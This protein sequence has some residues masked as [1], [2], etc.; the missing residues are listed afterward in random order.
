[1]AN[2]ITETE[3]LNPSVITRSYVTR[4]SGDDGRC[5]QYYY[6]GACKK[7]HKVTDILMK[8][9]EVYET[10][11]PLCGAKHDL[12]IES[13]LEVYAK[14]KTVFADTGN[15]NY[16]VY[17]R[18]VKFA[19][20]KKQFYPAN[21]TYTVILK[22]E[23]GKAFV[24]FNNNSA[25]SSYDIENI[26]NK[27]AKYFPHELPFRDYA[28]FRKYNNPRLVDLQKFIPDRRDF[29]HN[30]YSVLSINERRRIFYAIDKHGSKGAFKAIA[31][32]INS[33][34]IRSFLWRLD[35]EVYHNPAVRLLKKGFTIHQV[36]GLIKAHKTTG[37]VNHRLYRFL[38]TYLVLGMSTT[39]AINFDEKFGMDQEKQHYLADSARMV[40]ALGRDYV[41]PVH[42]SHPNLHNI[43]LRD[44]L[45]VT[46]KE[47]ENVEFKVPEVVFDWTY[48]GYVIKR[49]SS[50]KELRFVGSHMSHCVGSYEQSIINERCQIY[51]LY[52]EGDLE[53][54]LVCIEVKNGNQVNQA[55]LQRNK[56]VSTDPILHSVVSSWIKEFSVLKHATLDLIDI[57]S[58][59]VLLF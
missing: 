33:K 14:S 21:E 3:I 7:S 31:P 25:R 53:N 36:E 16:H 55:K 8:D 22:K 11:C 42:Y 48:D 18:T 9:S 24:K 32:T 1:M 5:T 35:M 45:A 58:P 54:P 27:V 39:K 46:E 20:T 29:T 19:W 52:K 57:Y 4:Y 6:C 12:H 17:Y 34:V 47:R 26:V 56:S 37:E 15:V 2:H 10:H 49:V 30:F 13:E 38:H 41:L 43:V 28:S 40:Q 51:V 23:S 59:F 50:S 44:Y